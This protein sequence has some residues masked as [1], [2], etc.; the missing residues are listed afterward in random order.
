MYT[1]HTSS[2]RSHTAHHLTFSISSFFAIH[3][4][5]ILFYHSFHCLSLSIFLFLF[6]SLSFSVCLSPW[7]FHVFLIVSFFHVPFRAP[8]CFLAHRYLHCVPMSDLICAKHFRDRCNEGGIDSQKG[9]ERCSRIFG[10]WLVVWKAIFVSQK[11]RW[12][13]KLFCR[14]RISRKKEEYLHV[15]SIRVSRATSSI[16]TDTGAYYTTSPSYA[17]CE[18]PWELNA[19]LFR[20]RCTPYAQVEQHERTKNEG[21]GRVHVYARMHRKGER[22]CRTW[23]EQKREGRKKKE[24]K[25]RT[26]RASVYIRA[27]ALTCTRERRAIAD[28]AF[29][30]RCFLC[31]LLPLF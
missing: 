2:T 16:N 26:T 3:S 8:P 27:P 5:S 22:E 10:S 4:I 17:D 13:A 23:K 28:F 1:L 9:E 6:F 12:Y 15:S 31:V 24:K 14:A 11:G 30:S 18:P 20:V 7:A 29:C 19:R 21:G 25:K